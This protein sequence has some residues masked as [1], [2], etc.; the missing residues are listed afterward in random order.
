MAQE[1][2]LRPGFMPVSFD[3]DGGAV[4]QPKTGDVDCL[5]PRVLAPSPAQARILPPAGIAAEMV[6]A[7]GAPAEL[8]DRQRLH[9]LAFELVEAVRHSAAHRRPAIER[10]LDPA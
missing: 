7:G 6:D 1:L 5:P 3:A 10:R 4:R 9:D 8:L 2:A